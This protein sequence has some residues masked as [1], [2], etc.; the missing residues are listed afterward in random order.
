MEPTPIFAMLA[1][2]EPDLGDGSAHREG[3]SVTELLRALRD[4]AA[5]GAAP[6]APG[7]RHVGH[8]PD[9]LSF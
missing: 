5:A 6:P 3:R 7:A 4:E 8:V 2:T 1:D 9:L